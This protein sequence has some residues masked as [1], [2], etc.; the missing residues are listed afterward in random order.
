M[1]GPTHRVRRVDR[2]DLAVDQ[3]VEQV[4]QGGEPLFDPGG[5]ASSRVGALIQVA[6]CTGWTAAI[7]A[8]AAVA[9][10]SESVS[11]TLVSRPPPTQSD[12]LMRANP[13]HPRIAVTADRCP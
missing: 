5:A 9:R 6:T 2:H 1:T 8:R 11:I 10:R 13:R 3:P 7:E 4:T 12:Y